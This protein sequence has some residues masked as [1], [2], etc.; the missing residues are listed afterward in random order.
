VWAV[1]KNLA[2]KAEHNA[3]PKI[4]LHHWGI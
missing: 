1:P 3:G 2:Y 4:S